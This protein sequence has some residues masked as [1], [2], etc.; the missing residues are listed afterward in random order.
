MDHCTRM[1][2]LDGPP[3]LN[4]KNNEHKVYKTR[5]DLHSPPINGCLK[6]HIV[7]RMA[8]LIKL[9]SRRMA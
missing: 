5:Q 8:G 2:N 3:L 4:R 6:M 7:W 1:L 9:R